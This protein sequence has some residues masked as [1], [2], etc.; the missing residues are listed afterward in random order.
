VCDS[1]VSRQFLSSFERL[2]GRELDAVTGILERL[3][4]GHES[5]WARQASIR[6]ERSAWIVLAGEWRLH[7]ECVDPEIILLLALVRRH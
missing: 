5:D 4:V 7:R 3:L 1:C 2:A 6:G